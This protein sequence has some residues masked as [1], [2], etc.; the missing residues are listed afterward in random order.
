MGNVVNIPRA[1]DA[2]KV[3]MMITFLVIGSYNV[4]Q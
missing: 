2:M 4:G 1:T 3:G